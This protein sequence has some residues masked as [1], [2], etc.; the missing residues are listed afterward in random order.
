M[1]KDCF[2]LCIQE[3]L[4]EKF[5]CSQELGAYSNF[6][7]NSEIVNKYLTNASIILGYALKDFEFPDECYLSCPQE[8][9]SINYKTSQSYWVVARMVK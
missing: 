9:D 2:E 7:E 8:C 4:K 6:L 1:Q 5:N 3:I